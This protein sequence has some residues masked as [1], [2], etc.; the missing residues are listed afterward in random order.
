MRVCSTVTRITFI[1]AGLYLVIGLPTAAI[2]TQPGSESLQ[3]VVPDS[4]TPTNLVSFNEIYETADTKA[5]V[6]A[7][8]QKEAA[9]AVQVGCGPTCESCA[10]DSGCPRW[11]VGVEAVW[12]SPQ[13]PTPLSTYDIANTTLIGAYSGTNVDGLFMTPRISL[14]YQTDTW[15]IQGRYWR[16]SESSDQYVPAIGEGILDGNTNNGIFKAETIDLEATRLFCW[17]D[18]TNLFSFGVRHGELDQSSLMTANQVYRGSIYTGSAFS[19]EEFAGT[20]LTAGLAGYKPIQCRN[21]CLFYSVRGSLLWD[22]NA[23]NQV[24]TRSTIADVITGASGGSVNGAFDQSEASMFIGEIQVG[25]QWNFELVKNRSDAFIRFA[26]EY[27]YWDTN[28]TGFAV[29]QSWVTENGGATG[30]ANAF[31]G[32]SHVDLIGFT[33]AT[34]FTW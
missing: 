4:A 6:K 19:R 7:P 20:G 29:A 31:A 17:R 5:D 16:M 33:V 21:F 25:A 22:N 11:I 10:K 15:G 28:D 32:D 14:G 3:V 26:L 8:A 24:E 13:H 18:T 23:L 27:Q 30:T 9:P 34:G 1:L 12:L 2:A